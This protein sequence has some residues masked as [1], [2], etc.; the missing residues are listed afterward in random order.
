MITDRLVAAGVLVAE[1]L[2]RGQD[3]TLVAPGMAAFFAFFILGI[4][5]VL[6]GWSM[7]RQVRRS[8]RRNAERAAAATDADGETHPSERG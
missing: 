7:T 3:P 6:L 2:E 5:V 4:V 8:E 1:Q